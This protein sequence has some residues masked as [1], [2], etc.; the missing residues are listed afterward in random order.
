MDRRVT[1]SSLQLEEKLVDLVRAFSEGI[2]GIQIFN[3]KSN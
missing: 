2:S 1:K 3:V